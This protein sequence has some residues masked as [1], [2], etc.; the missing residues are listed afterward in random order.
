MDLAHRVGELADDQV[1]GLLGADAAGHEA[2]DVHGAG[3]LHRRDLDALVTDHHRIAGVHLGDRDT[4]RPR[5]ADDDGAVHL[6][7][8]DLE[9][10][11][12]EPH[13]GGLVAGAVEGVGEDAVAGRG[14]GRRRR[15]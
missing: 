15:R 8:L 1:L 10:A 9:P 6:D 2:E 14:F 7:V 11:V 12:S 3:P 5:V 4:P 13:A